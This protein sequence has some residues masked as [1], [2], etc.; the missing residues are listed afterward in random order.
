MNGLLRSISSFTSFE[1]LEELE[2]K[3][4]ASPARSASRSS[5]RPRQSSPA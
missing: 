3:L 1:T 2:A 5:L 4:S